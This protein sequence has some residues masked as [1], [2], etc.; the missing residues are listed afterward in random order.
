MT[1][2]DIEFALNG[3]AEQPS[4]FRTWCSD[5]WMEHKDEVFNWENKFP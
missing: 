3:F 4:A 1:E 2:V 5:K